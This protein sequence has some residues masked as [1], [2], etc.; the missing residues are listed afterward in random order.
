MS[1]ADEMYGFI[2]AARQLGLI[3]SD[4]AGKFRLTK[5]GHRYVDAVVKEG[6]YNKPTSL[7]D[8]LVIIFHGLKLANE[9]GGGGS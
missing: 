2:L 3:E 4:G 7:S 6:L 5:T 8:E 9:H 1:V